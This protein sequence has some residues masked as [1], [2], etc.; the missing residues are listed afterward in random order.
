VSE[1]PHLEAV[2]RMPAQRLE[3]DL[4][5]HSDEARGPIE[6]RRVDDEGGPSGRAAPSEGVV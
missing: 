5:E 4:A 3:E 2:R 1:C 6:R